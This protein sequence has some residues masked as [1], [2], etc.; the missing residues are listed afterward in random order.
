MAWESLA[1]PDWDERALAWAEGARRSR[2]M[3]A[4]MPVDMGYGQRRAAAMA[5]PGGRSSLMVPGRFRMPSPALLPQ[6]G[7]L[8]A[9]P[10]VLHLVLAVLWRAGS[11]GRSMAP[12]CTGERAGRAAGQ[13][14]AASPAPSGA[15]WPAGSERRWW[16]G[17]STCSALTPATRQRYCGDAGPSALLL[18]GIPT[19]PFQLWCFGVLVLRSLSRPRSHAGD[20]SGSVLINRTLVKTAQVKCMA[21]GVSVWDLVCGL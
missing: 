9:R 1:R 10:V 18:P 17:S 6:S 3:A 20:A 12:S 2:C 13:S 11:P 19:L 14:R 8:Q 15:G 21:G 16:S 7:E 5:A 4:A